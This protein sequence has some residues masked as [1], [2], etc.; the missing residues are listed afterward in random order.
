MTKIPRYLSTRK[1]AENFAVPELEAFI[2]RPFKIPRYLTE[3]FLENSALFVLQ[4]QKLLPDS[5]FPFEER[6]NGDRVKTAILQSS[7][8]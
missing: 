7:C 2:T 6:L 4:T 1:R 5:Y 3:N 8:Q